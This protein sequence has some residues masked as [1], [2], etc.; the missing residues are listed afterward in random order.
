MNFNI[1]SFFFLVFGLMIGSFL[2]VLIYRIPEGKDF[3]K[4]RSHCPNC[5]KLVYWYE[6]I[7]VLSY[8]FLK[9]KC[10]KCGWKIPLIYPIVEIVTGLASWALMPSILDSMNFGLYLFFFSVF[11]C[12]LVHF[13]IDVKVQILPDVINIFLGVVFLAYAINF[14]SYNFWLLGAGVGYFFPYLVSYGFKKLRGLDG[15]GLGDVKLFGVLGIMLGP[16]GIVQNI[17]MSCMLGTIVFLILIPVFK[18]NRETKVPFGPF[19]ILVASAQ[20]FFPDAFDKF[21]RLLFF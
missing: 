17:F 5:G 19:I 21:S 18:L 8:L 15:L 13:I 16:L 6:N 2:N 14:Y 9:G 7:P 3:V 1:I 10:S 12:F 4:E 20:I 11:C